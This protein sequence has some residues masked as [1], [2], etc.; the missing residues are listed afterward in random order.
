MFVH[1]FQSYLFNRAASHRFEAGGKKEVMIGDL[2]LTED[3][4]LAEG[5]SGTSGL[6]GKAVKVINS[7]LGHAAQRAAERAGFA[8]AKSAAEALR[9]LGRQIGRSGIPGNAIPDTRRPDRILVPFGDGAVAVYQVTK[10]GKLRLKTTLRQIEK[11]G[12]R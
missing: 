4:S 10:G 7:N 2:V 5:G 11:V 3:K 1:A 8:D 9:K 12:E 6:K